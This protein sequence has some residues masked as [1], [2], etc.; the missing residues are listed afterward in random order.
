LTPCAGAAFSLWR[1]LSDALFGANLPFIVLSGLKIVFKRC[2][3]NARFLS[4]ILLDNA[5]AMQ[6]KWFCAVV[7]PGVDAG[8][9][10][11][12]NKKGGFC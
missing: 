10:L 1:P 6:V 7:C 3:H 5:G 9:R 2:Y 12:K 8:G 4:R 11:R